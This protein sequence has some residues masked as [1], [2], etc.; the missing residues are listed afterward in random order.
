MNASLLEIPASKKYHK[1]IPILN[2]TRVKCSSHKGA[3][4]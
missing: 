3:L 1:A 4:T 2:L